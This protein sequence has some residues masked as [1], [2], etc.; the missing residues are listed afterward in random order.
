ME[1]KYRKTRCGI[2]Q[3]IVLNYVV[4]NTFKKDKEENNNDSKY[5]IENNK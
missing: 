5:A 1:T 4:Q 3:K 2:V